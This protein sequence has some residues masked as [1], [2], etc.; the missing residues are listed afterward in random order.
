MY[1]LNFECI[2]VVMLHSVITS[3]TGGAWSVLDSLLLAMNTE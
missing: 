1:G 2:S 3:L